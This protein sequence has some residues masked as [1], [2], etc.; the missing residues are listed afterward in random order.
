MHNPTYLIQSRHSIYYFRYPLGNKRL[1]VSLKTRCPKEAL[2]LANILE[3]H[4]ALL[5][6]YG[7]GRMDH[8]EIMGMLKSYFAEVLERQRVKIDKDGPLPIEHVS[9]LKESLQEW[10]S[11]IESDVDDELEL[12]GCELEGNEKNPLITYLDRVI[13]HNGVS[14]ATDSK[15]YG[16]L[17]S[18][19]KFAKRNHKGP[20]E[21][22][23]LYDLT[24]TKH[25]KWGRNLGRWMND[26]YL[27]TLKLKT[28]KKSLHSLRHSLITQLSMAGVEVA[29]IKSIV[30]HEP[31][32]VTTET[33]T[34]YGVGHLPAFKAALEKLPY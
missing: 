23:L 9:R 22:R 4:S 3:Y 13:D 31:D 12:L 11:C 16:M 29:T 14:L 28:R 19:Y 5:I 18:S 20:Y 34:H 6:E 7:W 1:S 17:K 10:T 15:E 25:E 32:T 26:N 30:G 27:P 24:Y 33:Y 21:P 8:A 2:R